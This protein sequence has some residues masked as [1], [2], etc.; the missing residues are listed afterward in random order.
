YREIWELGQRVQLVVQEERKGFGHAVYQVRKHLDGEPAVM[1]LGDFI[2]KSNIE[3]SCTQQTINAYNKSGGKAV[4]GIKRIP[5]R[6]CVNYGILHG[7]FRA[8]RPYIMDVDRMVEK[9]GTDE[10][11]DLTV[12]GECFA[13]FGSYVVTKEVF[14]YL[15]TQIKAN[16]KNT[17]HSE[18]DM[19]RALMNTAVKGNLVGVDIDGT[20]FDVGRPEAYY[21]TFVEYGK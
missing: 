3:L 2:Y 19:T 11:M 9:P 15:E 18:I 8:D 4:V 1:L 16:M 10:G 7:I 5:V 6:E 14:D 21:R 20:S 13:T 12:G 17:E